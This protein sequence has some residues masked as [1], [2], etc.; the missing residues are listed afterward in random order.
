MLT[1]PV[2]LLRDCCATRVFFTNR[3]VN[4]IFEH[5]EGA[6]I[7]RRIVPHHSHGKQ[8]ITQQNK[9]RKAHC[10]EGDERSVYCEEIGKS[11]STD[12]YMCS[13]PCRIAGLRKLGGHPL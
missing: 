8:R 9:V 6:D 1:Y 12:D 10:D 5:R 4:R 11:Y 7:P 13:L 2:Y 3:G